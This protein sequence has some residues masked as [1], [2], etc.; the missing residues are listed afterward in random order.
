[1]FF[2][3]V[4]GLEKGPTFFLFNNIV[5]SF[6]CNLTHVFLFGMKFER[7]KRVKLVVDFFGF[8][9]ISMVL[10]YWRCSV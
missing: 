10:I 6:E 8:R 2:L 5:G 9:K 1:M 4:K 3:G 7:L